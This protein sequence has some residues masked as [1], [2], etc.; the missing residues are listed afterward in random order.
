MGDE[1][2]VDVDAVRAELRTK[3]P[4]PA[5]ELRAVQLRMGLIVLRNPSHPEHQMYKQQILDE[6]QRHVASENLLTMTTV[7]PS[8]VAIE[9]LCRRYPGMVSNPRIQKAMAYLSGATDEAEGK[10]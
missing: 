1:V 4:E 8:R 10:G 2:A 7:Y 5:Y 6:A 3:Y 9:G